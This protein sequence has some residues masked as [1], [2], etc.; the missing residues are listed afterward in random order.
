MRDSVSVHDR[1]TISGTISF[2]F[3]TLQ[4]VGWILCLWGYVHSKDTESMLMEIVVLRF[5][6]LLSIDGVGGN[7]DRT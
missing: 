5:H 1:L 6:L 3:Q 4:T 2:M 7:Q